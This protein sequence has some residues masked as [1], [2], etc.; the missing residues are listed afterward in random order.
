[1]PSERCLGNANELL[2]A[3]V[4]N[5]ARSPL[6]LS[7]AG[8]YRLGYALSRAKEEDM[9]VSQPTNQPAF[10]TRSL[11]AHE[12]E[13]LAEKAITQIRTANLGLIIS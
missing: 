9:G 3:T 11:P 6:N 2:H 12:R 1:M 10:V 8:M 7:A 4:C 5:S 13:D